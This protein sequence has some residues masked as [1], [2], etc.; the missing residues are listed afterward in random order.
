FAHALPPLCV[1]KP[2]LG[3]TLGA[4]GLSET[5]LLLESL[6]QGGLPGCDYTEQA[7]LPLAAGPQSVSAGSLLLA[8]YFGFGGNNASLV[9]QGIPARGGAPPARFAG[10]TTAT[11]SSRPPSALTC[12]A[13]HDAPIA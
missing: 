3:H 11:A 9:L 13:R 2:Y 8:N 4:C 10:A 12:P 1:L 6:R 7:L 5:L